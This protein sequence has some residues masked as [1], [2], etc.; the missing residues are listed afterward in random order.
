[1]KKHVEIRQAGRTIA[2]EEGVEIREATFADMFFTHAEA[3]A[4]R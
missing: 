2:V 3:A 1:M 4:R